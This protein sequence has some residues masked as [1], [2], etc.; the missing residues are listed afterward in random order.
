MQD[1]LV[2]LNIL[3]L[4]NELLLPFL[5]NEGLSFFKNIKYS[6]FTSLLINLFYK[7]SSANFIS[8]V[9]SIQSLWGVP[10]L[11]FYEINRTASK[12]CSIVKKSGYYSEHFKLKKKR[13]FPSLVCLNYESKLCCALLN[14]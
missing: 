13:I 7:H 14:S 5:N 2:V 8:K 9:F 4:Y 10:L 1:F 6:H 12:S 11:S 3:I